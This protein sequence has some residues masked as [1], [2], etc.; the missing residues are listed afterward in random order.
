[1]LFT[2]RSASPQDLPKIIEA[3]KNSRGFSDRKLKELREDI[4]YDP[5]I[6]WE[7]IFLGFVDNEIVA[8]VIVVDRYL[9]LNSNTIKVAGIARVGTVPKWRGNRFAFQIIKTIQTKLK[10]RGYQVAVLVT[11]IPKYYEKLNFRCVPWFKGYLC[12]ISDI[13]FVNDDN[14]IYPINY[15]RDMEM[16]KNIYNDNIRVLENKGIRSDEYWN[17]W[18]KLSYFPCSFL[19]KENADAFLYK[20]KSVATTYLIGNKSQI[21]YYHVSEC[22]CKLSYEKD[23][24]LLISYIAKQAKL[25]GCNNILFSIDYNSSVIKQLKD[26]KIYYE[27]VYDGGEG[28]EY[29]MIYFLDSNI[30]FKL[31]YKS[32]SEFIFETFNIYNPSIW[33]IDGYR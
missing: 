11:D 29:L 1:M 21:D 10:K 20:R 30:P 16:L 32:K 24:L 8:H 9:V 12:S 7:N 26:K 4:I 17:S 5:N 3:I 18:N 15:A 19:G 27:V 2:I 22:Y 14:S 28:N 33:D 31:G 25:K 23:M 13:N 6:H